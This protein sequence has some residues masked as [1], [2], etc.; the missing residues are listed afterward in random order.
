MRWSLYAQEMSEPCGCRY[1]KI[2]T[3]YSYLQYEIWLD[4]IYPSAQAADVWH[5]KSWEKICAV[6]TNLEVILQP[7][8]S[9]TMIRG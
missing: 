5:V 8:V 4:S 6:C 1:T 2:E 3:L 9:E 7:L